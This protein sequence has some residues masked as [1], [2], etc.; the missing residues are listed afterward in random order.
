MKDGEMDNYYKRPSPQEQR[1]RDVLEAISAL[2]SEARD[3]A[4][5]LDDVV[6][7]VVRRAVDVAVAD[8]D[9]RVLTAISRTG[10]RAES[11]GRA[12]EAAD[13]EATEHSLTP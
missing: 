7:Q 1:Y 2:G 3:L 4:E 9:R 6:W 13:R 8:H 11:S 10:R 12:S 5:E